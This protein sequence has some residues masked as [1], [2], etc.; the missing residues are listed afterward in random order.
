[1]A[2]AASQSPDGGLSEI[3]SALIGLRHLWSA[4][5]RLDDPELGRVEMSTIWV[6][7][8]VAR[9]GADGQ[10]T[11]NDVAAAL[12]VAPS[13][14]SRL[15]DRAERAGVVSRGRSAEDG[16][17]VTIALTPAGESLATRSAGF[18]LAYLDRVMAGWSP[19]QRSDFAALLTRFVSSVNRTPPRGEPT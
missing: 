15:V 17:R 7:E 8:A 16:R 11:V 1:V 9:S 3:D 14:A 4:P 12:D 5:P 18:R 13:T 6:A 2:D 10:P 19:A